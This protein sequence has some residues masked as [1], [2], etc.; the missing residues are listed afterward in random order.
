[1][2]FMMIPKSTLQTQAPYP[3][4]GQ[5]NTTLWEQVFPLG[6]CKGGCKV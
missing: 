3:L 1:M 6:H 5:P 2:H 4:E